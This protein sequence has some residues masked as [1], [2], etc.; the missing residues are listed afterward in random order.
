MQFIPEGGGGNIK[1]LKEKRVAAKVGVQK[2]SP[3]T[4]AQVYPDRMRIL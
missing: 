3:M 2:Q 1:F 4:E